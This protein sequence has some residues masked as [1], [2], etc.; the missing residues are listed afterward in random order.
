MNAP[1]TG[2]AC[3]PRASCGSLAESLAVLTQPVHDSNIDEEIL[4]RQIDELRVSVLKEYEYAR[5]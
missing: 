1:P 2:I 4:V 3:P 5:V